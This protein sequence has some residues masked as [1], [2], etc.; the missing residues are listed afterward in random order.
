MRFESFHQFLKQILARGRN[1]INETKTAC[2]RFQKRR[3]LEYAN[4]RGLPD[5][6]SLLNSVKTVPLQDVQPV[7]A[8]DCILNYL[9]CPANAVLSTTRKICVRGITVVVGCYNILRIGLDVAPLLFTPTQIFMYNETVILYGRHVAPDHFDDHLQAFALPNKDISDEDF[10]AITTDDLL[11][12]Q[13]L[14]EYHV[15]G[16]QYVRYCFRPL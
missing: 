7:H 12:T 11:C 14:S 3:C 5:D 2:E 8:K 6:I 10:L 16:L 4:A 1:F 15:G 13:T 9:D